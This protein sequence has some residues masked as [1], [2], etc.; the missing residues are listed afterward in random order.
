MSEL[1]FV[2]FLVRAASKKA[3]KVWLVSQWMCLQ[4]PAYSYLER[5]LVRGRPSLLD[6]VYGTA[7]E[8]LGMRLNVQHLVGRHFAQDALQ[9]C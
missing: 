3:V 2:Y 6:C 4:G 9:T 1:G 7:E 8:L 5:D